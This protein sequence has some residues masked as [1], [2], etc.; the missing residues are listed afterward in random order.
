[1]KLAVAV[2]LFAS[3]AAAQKVV[4]WCPPTAVGPVCI[5]RVVPDKAKRDKPPKSKISKREKHEIACIEP[6]ETTPACKAWLKK[7]FIDESKDK[8]CFK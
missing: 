1:M 6:I 4:M 3:F 2:L 7:C 8:E 5:S